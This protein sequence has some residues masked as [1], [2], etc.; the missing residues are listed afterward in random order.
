[1]YCLQR[2]TMHYNALP[3]T[4][5]FYLF[6]LKPMD[7]I[8][9]HV[10]YPP[11][12]HTSKP[13]KSGVSVG[14]LILIVV[15]TFLFAFLVFQN[16]GTIGSRFTG[17]TA[18]QPAVFKVGQSVSLSGTVVQ[19]GDYVTHTHTLT[20]L[21]GMVV[22]IKSKTVDLNAF[23]G[24]V[25]VQGVVQKELN[26]LFIVEVTAASGVT[27]QWSGEILPPMTQDWVYI[28][29][30]AIYL[31]HNF[32]DTYTLQNKWEGEQVKIVR[33]SNNQSIV[34]SYFSCTTTDES[35]DCAKMI[36]NF[37]SSADKTF[38]THNGD[39]FYKLEWVNSWF[40]SNTVFGY[41]IND[42][43]EQEVKDVANA[44][45]IVNP[46][47]VSDVLV[48]KILPLCTDG[49]M[50]LQSV[51]SQQLGKDFNGLYVQLQWSVSNGTAICKIVLDPSLSVGGQKLSF[52]VS[53]SASSSPSPSPSTSTSTASPSWLDFSVKQFPVNKEKSLSYTSSSK[54]YTIV[55]PS[56]NISYASVSLSDEPD[57][58]NLR[59]VGQ[60]N[61]IKYADKD[62]LSTHPTVRIFEC[63]AK[64]D[65]VLPSPAYLQSKLSDGR[66][67]VIQI[68][69]GAW[70]DF[71]QNIVIQ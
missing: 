24:M 50:T 27:L 10:Q 3:I 22:G 62:L 58:D 40:A 69:D 67:F 49:T 64:K 56:S 9:D 8:H 43:P 5:L 41:F 4:I 2:I 63:S 17:W 70:K 26:G 53:P 47:Y 61:V 39:K 42:I 21:D 19:N 48:P 46:T 29:A 15:V 65:I 32:N 30:A 16:M 37:V 28:S 23:F 31:D 35:K 59:C 20:L 52:V 6:P 36:K 51:S 68:M 57:I 1:M 45:T 54:W 34:V 11:Y 13:K 7:M 60:M 18:Q 44:M 33:N 38:T 14:V 71:A 55:F 66:I 25:V 12:G